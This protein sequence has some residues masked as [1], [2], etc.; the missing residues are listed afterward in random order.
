[1]GRYVFREAM[2][3][4][5]NDS[6]RNRMDK[7]GATIPYLR[8]RWVQNEKEI[9]ELIIEGRNNNTFHYINYHKLLGM[10]DQLLRGEVG[11]NRVGYRSLLSAIS[12]LLL[13]KWQREGKID[14]GIKC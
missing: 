10:I 11:N 14:V 12:V 9:R 2:K 13:Q 1:M 5:L 6:I 4:I 8:S 7:D 3:G